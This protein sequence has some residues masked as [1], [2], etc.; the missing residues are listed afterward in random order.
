MIGCAGP[1]DSWY[2]LR[3]LKL[4]R[5]TLHSSDDKMECI[6][7]P[8]HEHLD[9]RVDFECP[10]CSKTKFGRGVAAPAAAVTSAL[11]EANR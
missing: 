3:C 2:H 1:C 5:C 11:S 6:V 9:V 10:Q 4:T 7:T 8:T